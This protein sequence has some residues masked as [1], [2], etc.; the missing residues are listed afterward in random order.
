MIN[1]PLSNQPEPPGWVDRVPQF[2][3]GPGIHQIRLH[4]QNGGMCQVACSCGA[5]IKVIHYGEDCWTSFRAH[6]EEMKNAA[7][8]E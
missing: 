1:R 4:N 5:R 3:E 2:Q 8:A 7:Q 6:E